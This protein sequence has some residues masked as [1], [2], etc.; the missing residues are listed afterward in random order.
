MFNLLNRIFSYLFRHKCL[1]I[2]TKENPINESKGES[3][4]R[5]SLF[6]RCCDQSMHVVK[7]NGK[8]IQQWICLSDN[9]RKSTGA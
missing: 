4:G 3:L 7:K 9:K 1:F 6:L 2:G 5:R 8:K